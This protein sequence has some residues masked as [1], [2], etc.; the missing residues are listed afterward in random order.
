VIELWA[1]RC[2]NIGQ[3]HGRT[4]EDQSRIF[5]RVTAQYWTGGLRNIGQ[6]NGIKICFRLQI[7]SNRQETTEEY[8]KGRRQKSGKGDGR[9]LSK[10]CKILTD[11]SKAE[12]LKG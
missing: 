2:Q 11:R 5:D 8:W 6:R 12:Y 3:D 1:G 10:A 7:I 4:T 9:I